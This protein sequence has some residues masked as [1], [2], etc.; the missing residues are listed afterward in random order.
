MSIAFTVAFE[1]IIFFSRCIIVSE[2]QTLMWRELWNGNGVAL[3]EVLSY[4]LRTSTGNVTGE[5]CFYSY[6]FMTWLT[7]AFLIT[8]SPSTERDEINGAEAKIYCFNVAI[9]ERLLKCEKN[10]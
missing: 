7:K 1:L 9:A 4:T 8:G 3:A 10:K 5:Y 2:I 6:L